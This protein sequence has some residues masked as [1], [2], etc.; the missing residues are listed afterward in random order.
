MAARRASRGFVP[1]AI[2]VKLCRSSAVAESGASGRPS[3][4]ITGFGSEVGFMVSAPSGRGPP[5]CCP[6]GGGPRPPV[7][8]RA[9][10]DSEQS[11]KTP[12]WAR[13]S[14]PA[15]RGFPVVPVPGLLYAPD[16]VAIGEEGD[17]VA[18]CAALPFADVRMHGLVA[19]RRVVHFGWDYTYDSARIRPTTALPE[20][21]LPLRSRAAL[22]T[23]IAA[24]D[25]AETLVTL[26]PPGAGIGWHRDAP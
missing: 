16:F 19:R 15:P 11:G 2:S 1:S 5:A 4:F 13:N 20:W 12:K 18:R 6:C 22:L 26:Y 24:D 23:G 14:H 7:K 8:D 3:G 25:F 9:S 10:T 21:L 17:L